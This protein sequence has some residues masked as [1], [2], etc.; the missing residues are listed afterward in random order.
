MSGFVK[1]V[2]AFF[3]NVNKAPQEGEPAIWAHPVDAHY[4]CKVRT[5][6][7]YACFT[8]DLRLFYGFVPAA[9]MFYN[10]YNYVND[11]L[12]YTESYHTFTRGAEPHWLASVVGASVESGHPRPQ[13][14]RRA[15]PDPPPS[16]NARCARIY[17]LPKH[18][19]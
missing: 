7:F 18:P 8:L 11:T 13:R 12:Y 14:N 10:L 1:R 9:W 3:T 6:L 19:A 16:N 17:A 5:R 2:G 15:I 4:A